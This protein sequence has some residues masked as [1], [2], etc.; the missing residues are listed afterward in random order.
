MT[1]NTE[2]LQPDL[3]SEVGLSIPKEECPTKQVLAV[4]PGNLED[5]W[6]FFDPYDMMGVRNPSYFRCFPVCNA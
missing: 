5:V 6:S 1:S 3:Q 2:M 4:G